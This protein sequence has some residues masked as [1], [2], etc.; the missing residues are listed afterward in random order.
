VDARSPASPLHIDAEI[1][2]LL[3]WCCDGNLTGFCRERALGSMMD[4]ASDCAR[5]RIAALDKSGADI[6]LPV[7]VLQS[8]RAARGGGPKD[9]MDALRDYWTASTYARLMLLIAEQKS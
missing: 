1:V 9:K 5:E 3:G 2:V 4:A 7:I 8:A 6:S